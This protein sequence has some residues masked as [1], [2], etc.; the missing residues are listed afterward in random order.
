MAEYPDSYRLW[1][2]TLSIMPKP[3][4]ISG[5][6]DQRVLNTCK[7]TPAQNR[8]GLRLPQIGAIHAIHAHWSVSHEPA[9][10]V[11]PTGTGKTEACSQSWFPP[12]APRCWSSY[13]P[14][15]F[16]PRSRIS[17]SR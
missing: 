16:E 10:I 11:M 1:L 4:T 12:S 14:M 3:S 8:K 13:Q 2:A 15:L 9:T 5:F 7:K 17:S 6:V